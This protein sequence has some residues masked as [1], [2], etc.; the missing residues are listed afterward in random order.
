[1]GPILENDDKDVFNETDAMVRRQELLAQNRWQQDEY[2]RCVVGGYPWATLLHDTNR[3]VYTF[4]LPYGVSSLSIQPIPNKNLDL[5]NEC[6]EQL[7]AD[8]PQPDCEPIDDGEEAEQ[9][10]EAADRFL[11]QDAGEQGTNDAVLWNDRLSVSL[12]CST[13]YVELWVDPSGGGY[14]PLQIEAHPASQDPNSPLVG[15]D[16]TPTTDYVLRYV[17]GQVNPD[18]TFAPGAQFTDDPTQAAPQWQPKIRAAKW[19]RQHV[20]CFPENRPASQSDQIIILGHCTLGEAKKR[21]PS[22]EAMAPED[23]SA[24]C[25]WTPARYLQ[26]LP[27]FQRARW[28]LND[29]K[30]QNKMGSSD[31][32]IMFYYH[33]YIKACPD[34]PKGADVVMSGLDGGLI[35]DRELLSVEVTITKGQAEQVKETRCR[36]IPVQELTPRGDPYGQDP[37]GKCYASLFVGATEWNATLSQGYA[38]GLDKVLHTPYASSCLT[39][40]EGWQVEEARRSGNI[41][42]VMRAEDLPRQLD[43]PVL[44][45]TFFNMYETSNQAIDRIAHRTAAASGDISSSTQE[46]SGKAIQLAVSQNNIGNSS[47]LVASNTSYSRYNRLKLELMMAKCTTAQQVAYVGEDGA[48]KLMDLHAMD[49]ALIGK[50]AI[51]AGTGTGLTEDNKVQYL[52]NLTANQF[53]D[54]EEA[55]ES[56]RPSFSKR[57]GLPANPHEQYVSRCIDSWLDGPPAP[58]EADPN[59]PPQLDPTTGQPVQP[60]TWQQQYQAWQQDQMRFEQETQQFQAA[61]QAHTQFLTNAAVAKAGPPSNETGPEGQNQ[62]SGIDYEQAKIGLEVAS[63]QNPNIGQAPVPPQPVMVPKPWSPFS[64]RPNDTEPEL[65]AIWNRRLSRVMS[66]VEYGDFAATEPEW[67]D[68]FNRMYALTRQAKATAGGAPQQPQRPQQQKPQQGQQPTQ[69]QQPAMAGAA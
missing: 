1:M 25:D 15:P 55:K 34:Y 16:G 11:A 54:L 39:P 35:I 4:E 60:P 18:G 27:P 32:R 66:S 40:I 64:Q 8:F 68:D 13:S 53:V 23:L 7:L 38:E 36:E 31:E 67:T 58:P 52:G 69:P 46:H 42:Q 22:V 41:L 48:N 59:V 45:P 12:V 56:A 49:F 30:T 14:V 2:Y 44:P 28:K 17:A 26:L 10:A 47:M 57:L 61:S 33:R 50:V 65:S 9:A 19:E 20:R 6:C 24:L 43:P 5:V 21:W 62:K 63:M 37:T 3:D 51:K 29:G